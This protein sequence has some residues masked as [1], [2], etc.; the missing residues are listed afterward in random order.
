MVSL[1]CSV[2]QAA[3]GAARRGQEAKRAR[4]QREVP[5]ALAGVRARCF[6]HRSPVHHTPPSRGTGFFM[7]AHERGVSRPQWHLDK[8]KQSFFDRHNFRT[9]A[10]FLHYNLFS[11]NVRERS[12]VQAARSLDQERRSL[13]GTFRSPGRHSAGCA[14]PATKCSVAPAARSPRP[15][16]P[17]MAFS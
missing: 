8:D 7:K 1:L 13:E 3:R 10:T 16:A 15:G 17:E 11:Q 5:R 4:G 2:G 9:R 6:C 14:H 12:P